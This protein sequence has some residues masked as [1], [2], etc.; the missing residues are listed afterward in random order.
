MFRRATAF[1]SDLS[2]WSVGA[3]VD[4]SC[5][6]AFAT[7]FRSDLSAWSVGAGTKTSCMFDNIPA[8]DTARHAPWYKGLD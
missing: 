1:E 3:C 6:F 2:A 7:A 4:M 5:M 8:F